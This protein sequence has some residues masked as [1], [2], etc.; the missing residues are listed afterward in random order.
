MNS[1]AIAKVNGKSHRR[2]D[3]LNS[4]PAMLADFVCILVFV[5]IGRSS[6]EEGITVTGMLTTLWPF[7]VGAVIG[8]VGCRG[9]RSPT[10]LF[11]TGLA[12]WVSAVTVGMVLRLASD[13]GT[14]VSFVIVATGFLGATIVGWRLI[15]MLVARYRGP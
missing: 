1:E 10:R 11:P 12:V 7:V 15:V 4:W 13:Q 2:V 9:W 14:A 6:H 8:W 3:G 5:A